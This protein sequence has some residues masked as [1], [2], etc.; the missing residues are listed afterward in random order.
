[1]GSVAKRVALCMLVLALL[2]PLVSAQLT[3]TV[4]PVK[5]RIFKDEVAEFR[6]TLTNPTPATQEVRLRFEGDIE[7]R[8]QTSPLHHG[9]TGIRVP[10]FSSVQTTIQVSLRQQE[11]PPRQYRLGVTAVSDKGF[12]IQDELVLYLKSIGSGQYAPAV[13]VGVD[14]PP[15]VDTRKPAQLRIF[16]RNRNPLDITDLTISTLSSL[17]SKQVTTSLGPMEEKVVV[18][19]LDFN[20][21]LPPQDDLLIVRLLV[22]EEQVGKAE[23]S[24]ASLPYS[25]VQETVSVAQRF[26]RSTTTVQLF[27][28]GNIPTLHVVQ[29]PTSLWKVPFTASIPDATLAD[30]NLQWELALAPQGRAV[31]ETH[32]DFRPGFYSLLI[33]IVAA[34]LYFTFRAPLVLRKE[35]SVVGSEGAMSE[36]KVVLHLQNRSGKQ[37][38][39]VT[40]SDSVPDIIEVSNEFGLGTLKPER[41]TKHDKRGTIIRW[42]I[43]H[44][45]PLEER[46]ITYR[47]KAKLSIIGQVTLPAYVAKYHAKSRERVVVSNKVGLTLSR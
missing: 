33:L 30:G 5:D 31:I 14:F 46:I 40:V 6:L 7:W 13:S 18:Q 23:V 29:R 17:T 16:L 45:E 1:M 34:A 38:S 24:Y 41:M 39:D 2:M 27:N 19:D 28:D 22:G 37:L 35:A 11:L 25:E 8:Y 9:L 43:E 44:L 47:V 4:L 36:V 20:P 12:T 15:Q 42:K 32:E 10:A 21:V 26:L 3:S